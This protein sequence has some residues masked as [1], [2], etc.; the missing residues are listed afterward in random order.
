MHQWALSSRQLL[1]PTLKF[2]TSD[3]TFSISPAPS[4]PIQEE[5]LMG[6]DQIDDRYQ[7]NLN[8]LHDF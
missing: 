1:S 8:Q 5:D 3:P 6:K 2:F 4:N 7:Y